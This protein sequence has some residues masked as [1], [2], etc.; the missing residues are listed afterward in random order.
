MAKAAAKK[1]K[2]RRKS[3]K[4]KSWLP[5]PPLKSVL[6]LLFLLLLLVFSIGTLTYVVFFRMVVAAEAQELL[7]EPNSIL[8]VVADDGPPAGSSQQQPRIAIIIDDMGHSLAMGERFIT[9][10]ADLT[11]SFLPHAPFTAQLEKM[12]YLRGR[13][14]MLHL[15]LEP[16]D[17]SWDPG[18]GTLHLNQLDQ[19][20]SVFYTN[21]EQVP[22]ATGVNN[23]MG[24]SYSEQE[25][26]MASLLSLIDQE[27]LFFIDSF[28]SPNS[29]GIAM[30]LDLGLATA[31]RDL[32]LDN[33]QE[34]AA[35]CQKM[36]ELMS[37]AQKKGV[38]I[39]IAHP[40][41]ETYTAL[42]NCLDDATLSVQLVGVEH[43]I[44]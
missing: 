37:I 36:R 14:V 26:E 32:F 3:T 31:K 8:S 35:I 5:K 34:V 10:D 15:P 23:H 38:A 19:Q 20:K 13:T 27:H 33:T 16:K 2:T 43:L 39:G 29:V 28:T 9:F 30:A 17:P 24:S 40:Y 21:L 42:S 6:Y 41:P 4:K 12:A 22:H 7:G 44:R 25:N 11:F 18:P 1:R